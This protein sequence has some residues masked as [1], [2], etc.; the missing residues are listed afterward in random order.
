MSGSP[1]AKALSGVEL[2]SGHFKAPGLTK[3]RKPMAKPR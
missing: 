1:P 2:A 3:P